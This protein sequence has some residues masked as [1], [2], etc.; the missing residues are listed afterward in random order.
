MQEFATKAGDE[1]AWRQPQ[2]NVRNFELLRGEE[3]FGTLEFRSL[4]GT[5]AVASNPIQD[6]SFKRLGFLNPHIT[7][8][9][10]NADSDYALFFPK[11]FGGGILQLL[12]GRP[13]N[14]E[15]TNF[16]R[17]RWH[18]TDKSAAPIMSFD[19]GN[20]ERKLTDFL[21]LQAA[22]KVESSRITNQEFSI[23]VN[24]GFYLMV[25]YQADAASAGNS[26]A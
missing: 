18:F 19:L 21:K 3:A 2:N 26:A 24:L 4:W 1:L 9:H 12:D 13:F 8:R 23:M 20:E 25:L 14:W 6:W 15:P 17:T 10:P 16:W 22:V 11:V 5:L 7:I